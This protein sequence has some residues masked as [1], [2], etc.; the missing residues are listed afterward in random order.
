MKISARSVLMAGITTITASAVVIAPSVQPAPPPR[1]VIQLVA[2]SQVLQQQFDPVTA[3]SQR[4]TGI[5]IPPGLGTPPPSPPA[6][7]PVPTPGSVTSFVENAYIVIEPW[8]SYGFEV[9]AWAFSWVPGIGWLA[10]QI[11]PIGY[12]LVERIVR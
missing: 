12:G 9:G 8:V 7:A 1:P 6:P 3:L 5:V 4:L 10:P 11:W 2:S